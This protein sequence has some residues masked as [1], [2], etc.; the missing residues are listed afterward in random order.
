LA[1]WTA[2]NGI[3]ISPET[4]VA[5]AEAAGLGA[6]L[7]ALV[8]ELACSEIQAAGLNIDFHVNIGA[9]R[10]GNPYVEE[11]VRQALARHRVE[12]SRLVVEITEQVP[13]VDLAA[14]AD[15]I[16]RLNAFGV[17]V[18]LDDFGSGFNS[19]MYLHSLPV[20]I[21]KLDRR[22]AAGVDPEQDL[23]LYR[24]IIRLCDELGMAVIVEGVESA[25]QAEALYNAGCRLAQ[26]HL[27]G[28]AVPITE[29]SAG[30]ATQ[31]ALI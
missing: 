25:P 17:E 5:A 15:Q 18:A 30:S 13:I 6:D 22:F 29:L 20:Q 19:L 12:P 8:L 27:F 1:R 7:D 11:V 16:A 14:A 4:F 28:A 26:G 3:D 2:P 21:V 9:A 10:V 23:A 24:S 31:G